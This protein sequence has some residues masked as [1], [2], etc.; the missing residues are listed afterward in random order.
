MNFYYCPEAGLIKGQKITLVDRLRMKQ[1]RK[2]RRKEWRLFC[3]Q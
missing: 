2:Q 3:G 1:A